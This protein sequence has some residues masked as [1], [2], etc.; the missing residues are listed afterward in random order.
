MCQISTSFSSSEQLCSVNIHGDS[1]ASSSA[2]SGVLVGWGCVDEANNARSVAD[3]ISGLTEN[4]W[5][6]LSQ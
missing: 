1:L 2:E 6:V 3:W 4:A 5:L